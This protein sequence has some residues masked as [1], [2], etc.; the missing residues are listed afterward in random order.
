ML[1]ILPN[2][3]DVRFYNENGYWIAPKILSDEELQVLR[4]H[5]AK[6]IQGEY[7]TKRTP[8]SRNVEPGEP[9]KHIVKSTIA[10][11]LTQSSRALCLTPLLGKWQLS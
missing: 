5:H 1:R 8:W 11:G 2:E 9:L 3:D 10:I 7:A 4:E 6:V